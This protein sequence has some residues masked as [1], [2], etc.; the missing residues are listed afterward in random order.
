MNVENKITIKP[1]SLDDV[2]L[3]LVIRDS[4]GNPSPDKILEVIKSYSSQD[5]EII[6]AFSD[7]ILVGILGICKNN[8]LISIRHISVLPEFRDQGIG[9]L[10]LGNIRK[11][12]ASQI[13]AETDQESVYFYAKSGFS[14]HEFKSCYGNLRY[15]CELSL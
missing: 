2:R 8:R 10:L 6:G 7:N 14:C 3:P 4:I 11:Q 1:V 15:K 12:D 9:T 5:D 13:I